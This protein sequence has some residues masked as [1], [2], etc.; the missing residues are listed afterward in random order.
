MTR[1]LHTVNHTERGHISTACDHCIAEQNKGVEPLPPLFTPKP[2]SGKEPY[3][4][5][6]SFVEMRITLGMMEPAPE[7]AHE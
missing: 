1:D 2:T 4:P 3:N 7:D 6:G 5:D